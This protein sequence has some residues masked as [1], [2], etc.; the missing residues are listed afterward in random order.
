METTEKL[1]VDMTPTW[2]GLMPVMI[3]LVK[4]GNKV[5]EDELMK[6]AR[7]V[8]Q[9]NADMYNNQQTTNRD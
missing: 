6:L 7:S 2:E 8:D 5:A 1:E 4:Q 9:R 3:A